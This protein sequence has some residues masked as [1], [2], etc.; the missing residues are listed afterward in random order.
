MSADSPQHFNLPPSLHVPIA[1]SSL[2]GIETHVGRIVQAVPSGSWP[3]TGIGGE[4][5]VNAVLVQPHRWPVERDPKVPI[6]S[7]PRADEFAERL[8]PKVQVWVRRAYDRYRYAYVEHLGQPVP[9][10]YVLDHVQNRKAMKERNDSHPWLR[11]CPVTRSVNSDGGHS[12]GGEGLEKAYLKSIKDQGVDFRHL[13]GAQYPI[14]YAD[15]MDLTK[16]LNMNP[17]TGNLAGVA[18]VQKLF[19]P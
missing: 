15:P 4:D 19:Y 9:A 5:A 16:M 12:V 1:A 2:A 17:G 3:A 14:I 11:L 6:W 7:D 13:R 8:H 10:D 18:Q